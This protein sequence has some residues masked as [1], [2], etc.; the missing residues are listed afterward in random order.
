MMLDN[1]F[2]KSL[3]DLRRS[4]SWWVL[5]I[6]L[7]VG[8]MMAFYP[9]FRDNTA[10][11]DIVEAYPENLAAIF[12]ISD[13]E[14]ITS[15]EGFLN[16]YMFGFVTSVIVF[17]IFA[18]VHGS[19]AVAGEEGKGTLE[20]LMSEPITRRR[21]VLEKFATMV[22]ATVALGAV[23]MVVTLIGA[24]AVDMDVSPLRIVEMTISLVL[25]GL[26]FGSIAFAAGC[27]TGSRGTAAAVAAALAVGLYMLTVAGELAEFMD[28]AKWVTPFHYYNGA[29]PIYNGLNPLH[30]LVLLG[31]VVVF[32]V[33]ADFVFQRRD[34][35]LP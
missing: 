35:R 5:G 7:Y 3:R 31:I 1:V 32:G 21:V 8:F 12:G 9:S 29:D 23:L 11:E 10:F 19:G 20:V 24:F 27:L 4:Y 30:V 14:N 18:V 26:S 16:T 2:V 22:V 15:P 25:L 34:L 6:A 33:A 17:I 28:P 13:L